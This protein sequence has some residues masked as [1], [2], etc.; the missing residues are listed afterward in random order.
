[1]DL[2]IPALR[3][4]HVMGKLLLSRTP[5][6]TLDQP[7]VQNPA[8]LRSAG[9]T[10]SA[11]FWFPLGSFYLLKAEVFLSEAPPLHVK[12][13]F[14]TDSQLLLEQS[15]FWTFYTRAHVHLHRFD[16]CHPQWFSSDGIW[17]LMEW[18][19]SS[20]SGLWGEEVKEDRFGSV[21]FL[22]LIYTFY[23]NKEV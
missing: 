3:S 13:S 15:G 7:V 10:G 18:K 23:L 11:G 20:C 5:K 21:L 22:N 1:M 8:A 17:S 4:S 14:L 12:S 19:H 2:I 6:L 16:F 9:R